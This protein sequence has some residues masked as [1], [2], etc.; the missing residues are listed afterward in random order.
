MQRCITKETFPPSPPLR[1]RVAAYC[2]VSSSRKPQLVSLDNQIDHYE[3][4]FRSREDW[5]CAG[6]YTDR[7]LSGTK[8]GSRPELL[9]LLDDCAKGRI[10]LIVTKSISRFS[11]SAA[12]C[13]A[14]SRRLKAQG[15]TIY[16]EKEKLSTGSGEGELLFSILAA[17]A[18]EESRSLSAN[19]KW[20]VAEL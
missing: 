14:L 17:L 9:R 15:V 2:R 6:I 3:R 5:E 11:R 7:G 18:E 20:A 8:T 10:D 12:D 13:L 1:K 16:F 4:L 19:E